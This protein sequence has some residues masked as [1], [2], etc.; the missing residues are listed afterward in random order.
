M[1]EPGYIKLGYVE[2]LSIST[3]IKSPWKFRAKAKR[4]ITPLS[5]SHSLLHLIYRMLRFVP[6][7]VLLLTETRSFL[8][9]LEILF[10]D[11]EFEMH[12]LAA[13][14]N[15]KTMNFKGNI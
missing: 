3:G 8:V 6:A 15:S 7:T 14:V 12:C 1:V 13:A 10:N 11:D 2:L 9:Q 5:N 4:C